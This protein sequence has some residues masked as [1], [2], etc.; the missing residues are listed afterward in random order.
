VVDQ[1]WLLLQ[2]CGVGFKMKTGTLA[3]FP[4]KKEIQIVRSTKVLGEDPGRENNI[5]SDSDGVWT[6]DIGDSAEAWAKAAGKL[7]VGNS[8]SHTIRLVFKEIRA[9]IVDPDIC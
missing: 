4:N 7:V 5:E 8:R 9:A 3:G 1:L 2:G 6:I